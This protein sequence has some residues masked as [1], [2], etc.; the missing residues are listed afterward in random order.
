MALT[1]LHSPCPWCP[2][3]PWHL[4]PKPGCSI[5]PCSMEGDGGKERFLSHNSSTWDPV[6]F[7]LAKYLGVSLNM[8]LSAQQQ[9][10]SKLGSVLD[11]V[12][13]KCCCSTAGPQCLGLQR[14]SCLQSIPG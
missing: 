10:Q 13:L 7:T 3:A 9:A 5:Q 2:P 4:T 14:V 6:E 12:P 8:Y 11:A 1:V